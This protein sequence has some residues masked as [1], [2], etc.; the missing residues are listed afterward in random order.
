MA[1]LTS[2]NVFAFLQIVD[3]R[4]DQL[5]VRDF[6]LRCRHQPDGR[7][8]HVR[9]ASGFLSEPPAESRHDLTY[10]T[11]PRMS[12]TEPPTCRSTFSPELVRARLDFCPG[13]AAKPPSVF[14]CAAAYAAVS[15]YSAGVCANA[16]V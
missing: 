14:W 16:G 13:F 8:D 11:Q 1:I 2:S 10:F 6:E 15:A 7:R 5:R 3:R 4:L 9:L 12:G